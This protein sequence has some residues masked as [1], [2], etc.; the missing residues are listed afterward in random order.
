MSAV[1]PG[2]A[3]ATVRPATRGLQFYGCEAI[4]RL[5]AR[6]ITFLFT[7]PEHPPSPHT[8]QP[9]LPQFIAYAV[10]RAQLQDSVVFAGL[11]LLQRLKGRFPSANGSSGHRLFISACIIA[12]KVICDDTYLN[13][14]WTIIAQGLFTLREINQME[15]EMCSYL[16]WELNVDGNT[17]TSFIHAVKKDFSQE[18]ESYP[19]YPVEIVSKLPSRA[20]ASTSATPN[21]TTGLFFQER[22]TSR[23]STNSSDTLPAT[24]SHSTS[25]ASSA[26]QAPDFHFA[27]AEMQPP[28]QM[29]EK[30]FTIAI[31]AVW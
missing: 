17:M 25:P 28:I 21:A 13:N 4:A 19:T 5:S 29:K 31:P 9:K 24:R 15:R 7:C 2:A 20:A 14:S 23:S 3:N 11:V 16:D 1:R 30:A 12:S 6:F 18:R 27:L 10:H 22:K 26:S 8:Q